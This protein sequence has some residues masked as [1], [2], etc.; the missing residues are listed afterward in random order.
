MPLIYMNV[1]DLRRSCL[2][3]VGSVVFDTAFD[4]QFLPGRI[5]MYDTALAS[6][7]TFFIDGKYGFTVDCLDRD[8][9]NAWQSVGCIYNR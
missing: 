9:W 2:G 8:P 6:C 5:F 7:A 3:R 1:Q 4:A